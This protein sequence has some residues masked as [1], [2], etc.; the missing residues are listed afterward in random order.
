M[1]TLE[2]TTRR[3]RLAVPRLIIL[4][5]AFAA[6][7]SASLAGSAS[8]A[9]AAPGA[10][11]AGAPPATPTWPPPGLMTDI[12]NLLKQYY[13]QRADATTS[14]ILLA[15]RY[16]AEKAPAKK[17]PDTLWE[18]GITNPGFK[19][20]CHGAITQA[21]F[22]FCTGHRLAAT[23]G[24][25]GYAAGLTLSSPALT[26]SVTPQTTLFNPGISYYTND[27]IARIASYYALY[28]IF[29]HDFD[30]PIAAG[31]GFTPG[32]ARDAQA[33]HRA[34][35]RG[36]EAHAR[37]IIARMFRDT[38]TNADFQTSLTRTIGLVEMAYVPV[39]VF[40]EDKQLWAS[41]RDRRNAFG[42]IN[43]MNQRIWWEWVWTQT[44]G[45][46]TAGF[47]NLGSEAT[48]TNLRP[49]GGLLDGTNVFTYDFGAGAGPEVIPSLRPPGL[50]NPAL[51]TDGFWFDAD[52]PTPGEWWCFATYPSGSPALTQCKL[53]AARISRAGSQTPPG[54]FTPFG[55][56]FG[57]TGPGNPCDT[58]AYANTGFSCGNTNLGSEAEEWMWTFTGARLGLYIMNRLAAVGDPDLPANALGKASHLVGIGTGPVES[59]YANLS[60][61]LG[62]GV[63]G[64]NG[65]AGY[66]D[67]LE[68][69]WSANGQ[70]RATRTLSAG[71][72]DNEP[73]N[74]RYSVGETDVSSS[75]AASAIDGDTWGIAGKQEYP[76]GME[77]HTPG[78]SSL[79][80]TTV[81]QL[82]LGDQ[83]ADRSSSATGLAPSLFDAIHRN[84]VDE[85]QSWIWLYQSS[86][87]R[88]T[89][90]PTNDPLDPA[91]FAAG[92][93][94][95]K[96][97]FTPPN[98]A[99]ASLRFDYLWR[100]DATAFE[101]DFV[102]GSDNACIGKPGVPWRRIHDRATAGDNL[103][104]LHDEGGYGAYNQMLQGTGG[105][106]RVIAE[107]YPLNPGDPAFAQ[108]RTNVLK[109]WYDEAFNQASGI[110][111][112]YKTY[113]GY[114]PD[115]ENST[116]SGTNP[117]PTD[118]TPAMLSWQQGTGASTEA[119]TIRRAMFY[120]LA[121]LWN[122]WY[123]SNWLDADTF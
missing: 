15:P 111:S 34:M 42:V 97:L 107:R 66:N 123:D 78:P 112:L 39:V 47:V 101:P 61:R 20:A 31:A 77:N 95:R 18:Y 103:L 64:F 11:P 87:Y 117:D 102:A 52:Y 1:H 19:T 96:R 113:Y 21:Q 92:S 48:Y 24:R 2:Q 60:D 81:F 16:E 6:L 118:P 68:W 37:D 49:P 89:G 80:G 70:V 108:E 17:D 55:Q 84:H 74:G 40:M 35:A 7:L 121:A 58:R 106:M 50:D 56:Y 10:R 88:C 44:N 57:Q 79:Y 72:H 109:P 4:I 104:Y 83:T 30:A 67:D 100:Y 38:R 43:A 120:S 65:G 36:Y 98:P 62:Y 76:G 3:Q 41:N 59:P 14:T 63:A 73:Q 54:P 119:T 22:I 94:V 13:G 122:Y 53:Q 71:R 32:N 116:C 45:P 82:L 86:Y 114:V 91:C 29:A 115:I 105:L 8:P 27:A 5:A 90:S 9:G 85:F 28:H 33:Y 75:P 26:S 23:F 51:G 110:I 93:G 69:L 12:Q 46:A 25:S 99:S